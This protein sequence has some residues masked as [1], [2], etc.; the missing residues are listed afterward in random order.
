MKA[1]AK[2][3]LSVFV[4]IVD[5]LPNTSSSF[6]TSNPAQV[7]LENQDGMKVLSARMHS[8]K[9]RPNEHVIAPIA[10]SVVLLVICIS[11]GCWGYYNYKSNIIIPNSEPQT[12]IINSK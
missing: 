11:F 6:P 4:V 8:S 3:L 5:H 10:V 1:Y 7:T 12:S 2:N 9:P